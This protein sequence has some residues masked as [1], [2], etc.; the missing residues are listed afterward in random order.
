MTLTVG[1][2]YPG[3]MGISVAACAQ[4]S[5]QKVYW[6]SQGRSIETHAR[7]DEF[8]LMDAGTLTQAV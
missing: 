5:G 7:A 1:I 6:A 4:N 2:L 3:E 8:G